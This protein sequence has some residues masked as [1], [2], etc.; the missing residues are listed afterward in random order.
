MPL[1]D[2]HPIMACISKQLGPKLFTDP[3]DG[4]IGFGIEQ[5]GAM[6]RNVINLLCVKFPYNFGG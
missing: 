5:F 3:L 6:T 4:L 2:S 1:L